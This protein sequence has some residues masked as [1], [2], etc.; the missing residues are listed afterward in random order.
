MIFAFASAPVA[1]REGGAAMTHA[2]STITRNRRLISP[3]LSY[4]CR[5][6]SDADIP[7][8]RMLPKEGHPCPGIHQHSHTRQLSLRCFRCPLAAAAAVV[9]AIRA[10]QILQQR[11]IRWAVRLQDSRALA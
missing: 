8:P 1:A 11:P 6:G 2:A 4:G 3:L 9:A 5:Y 10:R 7:V